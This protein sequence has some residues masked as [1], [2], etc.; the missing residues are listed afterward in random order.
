MARKPFTPKP[1]GVGSTVEWKH[2]RG[3]GT[4]EVRTGMV[5]GQAPQLGAG[6]KSE[7]WVVPDTGRSSDLYPGGVVV[8]VRALTSRYGGYGLPTR[9]QVAPGERFS[10]D[11]LNAATGSMA[12][13]NYRR[14]DAGTLAAA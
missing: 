10:D 12:V 3:N 9:E 1:G 5:I 14:S 2:V 6:H 11:G 4:V 13:M 8:A 7:V